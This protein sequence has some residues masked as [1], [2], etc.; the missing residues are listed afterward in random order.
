MCGWATAEVKSGPAKLRES[1]F[2]PPD[3]APAVEMGKTV[4]LTARFYISEFFG[5]KV[6]NAGATVKNIG[7]KPMFYVFHVAFFDKENHL[8]GCASQSSFGDQGLKPGEETQLGSLMVTLPASELSKVSSYQA[9]FYES[10][11]KL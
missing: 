5:S 1:K 11:H 3:N 4:K 8:L 7:S 9:A 2:G 6:I 10:D